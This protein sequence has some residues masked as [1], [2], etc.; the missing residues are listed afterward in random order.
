MDAN[1]HVASWPEEPEE[2]EPEEEV[3]E[4]ELA[5]GVGGELFGFLSPLLRQMDEK[6]D[7]RLVRTF[8]NTV[9]AIIRNRNRPLALLLSELGSLLVGPAHAP[10]GIKRLANLVHSER[11]QASFI[12]DYLIEQGKVSIE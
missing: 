5:L 6:L 8:A 1:R 9:L 2:P 3:V 12:E 7:L 4:A 10:A 11:W